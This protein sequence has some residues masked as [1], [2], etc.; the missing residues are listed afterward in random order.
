MPTLRI[1]FKNV[2]LIVNTEP[3]R[4]LMLKKHHRTTLVTPTGKQKRL[5]GQTV[6]IRVGGRILTGKSDRPDND[7][8]VRLKDGLKAT[9]VLRTD[10]EIASLIGA[11]VIVPPGDW[12]ERD[13]EFRINAFKQ[14]YK[15]EKWKF[16]RAG[17]SKPH[18]QKLTNIA[19]HES[20]LDKKKEYAVY[21][22]EE[23]FD[24]FP[25]KLDQTIEIRNDDI[26]KPDDPPYAGELDDFQQIFELLKPLEA[27]KP[28]PKVKQTSG[29][30]PPGA[31]WTRPICPV[32]QVD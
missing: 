14:A 4:M 22:G 5:T 26:Y 20:K 18:K 15:N 21:V 9:P 10:A 2:G 13:P 1:V 19:E 3:S 32:A 31:G 11:E 6:T 23:L 12:K 29:K 17:D 16:E 7:R 28:F 8:L 24:T 30:I 25:G 27:A